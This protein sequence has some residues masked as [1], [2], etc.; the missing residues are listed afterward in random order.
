MQPPAAVSTV[1]ALT[2][3]IDELLEAKEQLECKVQQ[4][5][6]EAE[7]VQ[8]EKVTVQAELTSALDAAKHL[9]RD[10][11]ALA[12]QLRRAM[13]RPQSHAPRA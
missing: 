3:R 10:K 11:M 7:K 1:A 9:R 2:A 5:M 6:R 13:A 12:G 4:Y 8:A